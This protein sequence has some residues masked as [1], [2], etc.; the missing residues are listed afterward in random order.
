MTNIFDPLEQEMFP[1][2]RRPHAKRLT[3]HL[4]NCSIYMS[5]AIEVDINRHNMIWLKHPPYSPNLAPSDCYLFQTVKEKLKNI[6]MV[7]ERDLFCR[8]QELL[9]GTCHQELDKVSGTWID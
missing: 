8:L 4:E 5:E 9:N 2:G 3:L 6:Q 1:A 7:D